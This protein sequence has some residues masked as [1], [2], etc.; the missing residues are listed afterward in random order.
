[1]YNMYRYGGAVYTLCESLSRL[2]YSLIGLV[3]T[4]MLDQLCMRVFYGA[5]GT[6]YCDSF[7]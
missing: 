2:A 3:L 5:S 7:V 4:G 6:L 1:M